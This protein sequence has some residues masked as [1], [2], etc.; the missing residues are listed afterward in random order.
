MA[1][2]FLG[3]LGQ[4]ISEWAT[5]RL[6]AS[7]GSSVTYYLSNE[8]IFITP[9]FAEK[10]WPAGLKIKYGVGPLLRKIQS[11]VP[12]APRAKRAGGPN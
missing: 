5:V 11:A 8:C 1:I 9:I 10:D 7:A 4:A 2:H 3:T 12:A 6:H